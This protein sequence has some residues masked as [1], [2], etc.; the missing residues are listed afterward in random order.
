MATRRVLLTS[1]LAVLLLSAAPSA[2]AGA[3]D[4]KTLRIG[5][6]KYGTLIILKTKGTLET[7]LAALGYTVEWKEFPGGPQ[8]L[9]ALNVGA[10]DAGTTGET[11]PVFAQAAGAPL[12][13]VGVE[14]SA[15]KGEAILLPKDSK[16][17]SV[18]ELK[19]KKV[20]LN[21]GSN[22]HYLLARALEA[23]GLR[24]ADVESIFLAPADARA[25]FEAG[26]V[27][28][29]VIWDPFQAAAEAGT[30]ARRLVDGSGLVQNY[31]YYLAT[32]EYAAK[33]PQI[34]RALL[35]E[36]DAVDRWAS[37]HQA[38]VAKLLSPEIGLPVAILDVSLARLAYGVKPIT[39]EILAYQQGI[40]D[41]FHAAGLLPKPITV[42]EA[43]WDQG[44]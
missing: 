44:S 37:D 11:P 19:G 2:P 23:N 13:Y 42:R 12:V 7:R 25:A 33:Q 34:I 38:E 10:I 26:K 9:E 36:I 6:Q 31:Q 40:A 35:A 20:A 39:P 1:M 17:T 16:I 15:P 18:A 30:G 29:W 14:P 4:G 41:T 27:D 21:K 3:G 24:L 8:L 28:A 32:R 43:A 5:Y 22:V